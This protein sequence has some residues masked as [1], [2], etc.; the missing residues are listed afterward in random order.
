MTKQTMAFVILIATMCGGAN[1]RAAES[2]AQTHARRT[3]FLILDSRII[4][5]IE[6][7][8]LT[9]GKTVKSKHNPL[10]AEDRA[11]EKRFDNLYANVIYDEQDQLYKCWYSPCGPMNES[12]DQL[13]FLLNVSHITVAFNRPAA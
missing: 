8:K 4:E 10:M 6:N 13:S 12:H 2:S 3:R 1:A 7:A 9:L 11:W 5:S